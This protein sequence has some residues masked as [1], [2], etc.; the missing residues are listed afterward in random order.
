MNLGWDDT[1]ITRQLSYLMNSKS[2]TQ[3]GRS[4]GGQ[5]GSVQQQVKKLYS[6]YGV[7]YTQ[8]ETAEWSKRILTGGYSVEQ[9]QANLMKNAKSRYAALGADIDQ[10]RT[11]REIADPYVQQMATTLELPPGTIDLYDKKIQKALSGRD[12]KGQPFVTPLW[13]FEQ[14]LKN[15]PRWDKTKN[16]VN[17][18]YDQATRIGK[19][20][21]FIA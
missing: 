10:G 8:Q 13:A 19:D 9:L 2:A 6:D 20:W 18:A 14:D 4:L 1:E 7:K 3:G 11:V 5:A 12:P 16:A 21:G 15:D 17:S